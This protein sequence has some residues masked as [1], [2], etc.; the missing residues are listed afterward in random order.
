MSSWDWKEEKRK[1]QLRRMHRDIYCKHTSKVENSL[2][3]QL[4]KYKKHLK[5]N[6]KNE[7]ENI[8]ST[9]NFNS[10]L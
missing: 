5:E 10:S 4:K 2:E 3:K 8:T 1:S 9:N 7:N 6:N